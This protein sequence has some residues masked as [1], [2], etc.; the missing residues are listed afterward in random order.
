MSRSPKFWSVT[1]TA[2]SCLLA[3]RRSSV[4][5]HPAS[6]P[7]ARPVLA[8]ACRHPGA[9]LLLL[10]GGK[11]ALHVLGKGEDEVD[12]RLLL[13]VQVRHPRAA[14]FAPLLLRRAHLAH[15]A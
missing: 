7:C 14:A 8:R 12:R 9:H 5:L 6:H 4:N 1:R 2:S 11:V 15:P 13:D 3:M 10:L